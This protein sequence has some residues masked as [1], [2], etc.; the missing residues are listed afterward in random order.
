[1]SAPRDRDR[2]RGS[3]SLFAVIFTLV[4]LML[5]GLVYDGGLAIAARQ[6]AADVAE[7]AARAGANAVD[8]EAFRAR[9]V[10]VV[11]Q[12]EAC[13]NAREV[14][15]RD[16]DGSLQDCWVDPADGQLVHVRVH[17][18]VQPQLLALFRFPPFQAEADAGARPVQGL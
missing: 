18:T 15:A 10:L 8:V 14:V 1:M 13:D 12:A 16:G 4:V 11:D 9:Q 7:S 6:R 3:L 2:E 17:V 5:A